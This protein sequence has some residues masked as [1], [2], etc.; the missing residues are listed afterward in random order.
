MVPSSL[1]TQSFFIKIAVSA[2]LIIFLLP[3]LFSITDGSEGMKMVL[4]S[5]PPGCV[6]KCMNC[7]PCIA[8]LV[9]PPRPKNFNS[10]GNDDN[11][12]YYLLSWMCRC[13]KKIYQP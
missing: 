6:N 2:T 11:D 12:G 7:R 9:V 8:T 10:R 13:G 5:R 4:G 3:L 1:P